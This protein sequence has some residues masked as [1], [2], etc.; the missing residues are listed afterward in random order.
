M[1]K[2]YSYRVYEVYPDNSLHDTNKKILCSKDS[3]NAE[4]IRKTFEIYGFE[5][6]YDYYYKIDSSK[7]SQLDIT[8]NYVIDGAKN[9]WTLIREDSETENE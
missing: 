3:T 5:N 4:I 8:Y 2:V 9:T 1:S 6:R 7:E